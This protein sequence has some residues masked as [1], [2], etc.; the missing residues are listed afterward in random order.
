M[1]LTYYL[2]LI[3][4]AF[5]W[6]LFADCPCLGH[7]MIAMVTSGSFAAVE[8]KEFWKGNEPVKL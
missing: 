3:A 2:L 8:L 6:V 7:A 5:T 4:M 1:K